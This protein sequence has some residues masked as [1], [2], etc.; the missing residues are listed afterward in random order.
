MLR[1]GIL[2]TAGIARAFFE[3]PL[4][5]ARIVA[6]ASR[7]LERAERFADELGIE[8]RHGS[9]ERLLADPRVDAVYVPLPPHQHAEWVVRAARAG[10]HVLV[11]KP[12]ACTAA[13]VRAM[14]EACAEA[15]VVGMEALMYRH[16]SLH[17]QVL[18]RVRAG[19]LGRV[20]L[21]D[22]R[23]CVN[24]GRV[25]RSSF[26]L[27]PAAGGGCLLDLGVYGI[28]FARQL[29]GE[30]LELLHAYLHRADPG[31]VEVAAHALLRAGSSRAEHA[32][33]ALRC[34]FDTD[35]NY[36]VV[37]GELGSFHVP[38]SVAGRRVDNVLH[39]HFLDGDRRTEERFAAENP[40][41]AEL[42]HFAQ[43]VR[44]RTAPLTGLDNA[45][46]NLEWLDRIRTRAGGGS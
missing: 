26:R 23:W 25:A 38:S 24:L 3:Q 43:C 8:L 13:E 19:E 46:R 45:C 10:K 22:F 7:V 18:A 32:T 9:Y 2:G 36:Y 42:E 4:R 27:D 17:Q 21:L 11:E 34:G 29:L 1:V 30:P 39:A 33:F 16:K 5:E 12:A 20:R 28:D 41:V 44:D 37:S 31:G 40:Y 14:A 15:G 35:A 6:V